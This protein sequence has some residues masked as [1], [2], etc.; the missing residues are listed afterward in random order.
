MFRQNRLST[1][2]A[3][4]RSGRGDLDRRGEPAVDGVTLQSG[5]TTDPPSNAKLTGPDCSSH[6]L[7]ANTDELG[8]LSGAVEPGARLALLSFGEKRSQTSRELVQGR[9]VQHAGE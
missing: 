4:T 3:T 9:L 5:R 6:R 8:R 2:G 7:D 1:T